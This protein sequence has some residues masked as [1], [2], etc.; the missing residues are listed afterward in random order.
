MPRVPARPIP[1]PRRLAEKDRMSTSVAGGHPTL[2]SLRTEFH[3][4]E[5]VKDLIDQCIDITLN[6]RQSGHPG[7]SRSKVHCMVALTLSG[8]MRW[9]VRSPEKPFADRFVL[10]AGHT[11]PV[12]YAMLAVYN[13]A[14]RERYRRTKDPR[15]LVPN[16]EQVALY[17]EDLLKLRRQHGLPGHAEMEGKTLFFKFNTGP[18]GHGSP[19][20]AGEALALKL[21]GASE[22]KVFAMEGEGGHTAGATHETKHTAW[23]LGLKNL[24]YLLDWNDHG[25]DSRACS[26]VVPGTPEDWFKPYGFR[27]VGT[28][29]GSDFESLTSAMHEVIFGANPDA[30]PRCLW[31]KT[32]KGRG[33]GVYDFKSHGEAHKRNSELFWATKK[34]FADRY[35]LN[36]EDFGKPDPVD[37]KLAREQAVK[38]LDT[39]FSVLAK[40]TAL[41]EYLSDRLVDLGDSVPK[42][43]PGFRL[44]RTQDI[45]T[46]ATIRDW[47]NYP[48]EL[49]VAPGTKAPNRKGFATFGAWLNAHGK[50]HYGRPIVIACSADLAESTNI[51]GFA[52]EWGDFKGFG[53]YERTQNLEGSL[54]PTQITEF[55]NAGLMVGLASVNMASDPRKEF[56]GFYGA[57]STY[58]SFSYLKYGLFR[59]FSQLAQDCPLKVGRVIWVAGHSGP[60]TAED[61]R[62]H[63]GIFAPSVTQLFPDGHVLN[64]YPYEHNEVAPLLGAALATDIPIIALH[65]TRPNVSVPDRA[66]LGM[67]SYL[68]AGRGAYLMRAFDTKSPR[69]GVLL[70]QGT[71][72]T[73]QVVKLLEEGAFE[74]ER[75][76]VK[77]V[78]CPSYDLFRLQ[79]AEYR[80]RL[81]PRHEWMDSTVIA[82]CARRAMRDWFPHKMAEEY[83]MTPDWDDRWRTGG[84]V[85]EVIDEARI[86][87]K[88][89]LEGVRRFV[90]DRPKRLQALRESVEKM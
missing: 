36:F 81:L 88:W 68:E 24:V 73:E 44:N 22:V 11:N 19:A 3:H 80:D 79:P 39:V 16:A 51:S 18:S 1:G 55:T 66:R 20:A 28:D 62:T 86:N 82:N 49:Y 50:K 67:D 34:E 2:A 17:P 9:D 33:Y 29:Q 47:R 57:C 41:L 21:A 77:I 83:A 25:I 64:L 70:V 45:R 31:F 78:A 15:F 72:C 10:V 13:Q 23:G 63:F 52:K 76:N 48:A 65:L 8:A 71:S 61:S 6:H 12:I 46:D 69:G 32:R 74:R 58:G 5:K 84:S 89:I 54:L 35:A 40:D 14:L 4:W 42:E 26:T 27:T 56:V 37:A 59:L 60:E 38:Q 90:T 43:I 30:T 7:G 85:D 53:R 87:A 75:L